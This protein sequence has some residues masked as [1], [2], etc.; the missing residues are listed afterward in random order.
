MPSTTR[1][2]MKIK[3][4]RP[5]KVTPD[6]QPEIAEDSKAEAPKPKAEEK[7]SKKPEFFWS[8]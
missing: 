5:P 2:S 6:E 7:A 4:P 3:H 8:C 1:R